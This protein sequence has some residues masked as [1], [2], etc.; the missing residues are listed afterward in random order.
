VPHSAQSP[1]RRAAPQE[2]QKL[3]LDS[4]PQLEHFMK[5]T[6]ETAVE[7]CNCAV[8]GSGFAPAGGLVLPRPQ[9]RVS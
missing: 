6:I 1:E 4:V 5:R 8:T 9:Q 2:E 3:P 7:R